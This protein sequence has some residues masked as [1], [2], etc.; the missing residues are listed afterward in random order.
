MTTIKVLIAEDH[1][2]YRDGL[3]EAINSARNME[4][5]G[6]AATGEET[7]RLAAEYHPNVILMDINMPQH[8]GLE[9]TQRIRSA[10]QVDH[11]RPGILILTGDSDM[12]LLSAAIMAG[13][14]GYL[15]KHTDKAGLLRAIEAVASGQLIFGPEVAQVVRSLISK[16]E[17]P[18]T[19]YLFPELTEHQRNILGFLLEGHNASEIAQHLDREKKT[20]QNSISAIYNR[21]KVHGREDLLQKIRERK[22]TPRRTTYR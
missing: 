1:P 7:M 18:T 14:D 4:V 21:L 16:E 15:L 9:V 5:V 6:Q 22:E 10:A 19:S 17:S 11:P 3:Y 13:A 12:T 2:I 20:I 8:D